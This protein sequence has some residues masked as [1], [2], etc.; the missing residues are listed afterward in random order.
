[1]AKEEMAFQ[2]IE[3][4]DA[5]LIPGSPPDEEWQAV[6]VS[7][8]DGIKP[9]DLNERE[10]VLMLQS[11]DN[12][13]LRFILCPSKEVVHDREDGFIVIGYEMVR[14][15]PSLKKYEKSQEE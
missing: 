9:E 13:T 10:N 6:E 14:Y 1:M 8:E 15:Y 12:K 5:I 3:R 7:F 11:P 4:D 2:V